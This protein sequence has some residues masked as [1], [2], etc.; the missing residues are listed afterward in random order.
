MSDNNENETTLNNK[1]TLFTI[2]TAIVKKY[3]GAMRLTEED[4]IAVTTRDMMTLS[5]D[6]HA[7]EIVLSL[8]FLSNLAGDEEF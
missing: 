8:H 3:G 4:L 1:E 7:K 6:R 2:L 5:Y